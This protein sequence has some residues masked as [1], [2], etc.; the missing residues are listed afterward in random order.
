[1]PGVVLE[2]EEAHQEESRDEVQGQGEEEGD[3]EGLVGEVEEGEEGKEG[4]GHLAEAP[5]HAGL[6][7]GLD[8][9]NPVFGLNLFHLLLHAEWGVP[10]SL[11]GNGGKGQ[12]APLSVGGSVP[13]SPGRG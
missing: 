12:T 11:P 13:P 9:G 2:D 7:V 4:V 6:G 5:G 8:K 1:M 10:A 3:G